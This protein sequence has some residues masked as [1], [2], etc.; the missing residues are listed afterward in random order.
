MARIERVPTRKNIRKLIEPRA[1]NEQQARTL[2]SHHPFVP[3]GSR[4]IDWNPTHIER[5]D[6]HALNRIDENLSSPAMGNVTNLLKIDPMPRG[7][8]NPTE[9]YQSRRSID[10][11]CQLR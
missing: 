9:T 1:S 7:I 11:R 8:P 4:I 2:W 3:I 6:P 5:K 10:G